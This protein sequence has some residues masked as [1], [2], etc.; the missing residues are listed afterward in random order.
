LSTGEQHAALLALHHPELFELQEQLPLSPDPTPHPL[1]SYP[2]WSGPPLSP[3]SGTIAIADRLGLLSFHPKV[4]VPGKDIDRGNQAAD[5]HWEPDCW[6]G[7]LLLFLTDDQ[8]PYCVHWDVKGEHGRHDKAGPVVTPKRRKQADER[9]QARHSVL[10]SY[11]AEAGIRSVSVAHTEID[12]PM[13][14]NLRSIFG[15][16]H[17]APPPDRQVRTHALA[18]LQEALERGTPPIEVFSTASKYWELSIEAFK[19]LF[20]QAIWRRK[21]RVDLFHPVVVDRPMH[22]EQRDVIIE[23]RTWYAR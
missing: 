21:L 5:G 14:D 4:W 11:F 15:W 23:Y 20:Y 10:C 3:I 2:L 6:Y 9:A 13:R 17:K 22:P 19:A 8:G 18:L 16:L 12:K 1:A 7:D